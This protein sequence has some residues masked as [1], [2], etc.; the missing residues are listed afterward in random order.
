MARWLAR[1]SLVAAAG[2]LAAGAWLGLRPDAAPEPAFLVADQDRDLGAV[3]LGDRE[4]VFA[5]T[6]PADRPRRIIGLAEG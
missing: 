2:C 4:L 3:P 6:N 1:L 5:V